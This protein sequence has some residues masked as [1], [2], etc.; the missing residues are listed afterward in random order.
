[1]VLSF[2]EALDQTTESKYHVLLGNGFSMAA[3]HRITL[4]CRP[5][6]FAMPALSKAPTGSNS[7]QIRIS[8]ATPGTAMIYGLVSAAALL[9]TTCI[10]S[11]SSSCPH[12]S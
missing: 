4:A 11:R 5:W 7:T 1:M 12:G 6:E 2:Q 8:G 3:G 9:R 10:R